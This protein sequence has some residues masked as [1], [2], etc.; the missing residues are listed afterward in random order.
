MANQRRT[1]LKNL[2]EIMKNDPAPIDGSRLYNVL[3]GTS[4][5]LDEEN[6][7]RDG[8]EEEAHPSDRMPKRRRAYEGSKSDRGE[9]RDCSS[10]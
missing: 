4:F 1:A 2:Y 8:A 6:I 5:R 7:P 9:W 3:Y 10:L